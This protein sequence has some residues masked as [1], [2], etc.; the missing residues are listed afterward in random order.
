MYKTC[1]RHTRQIQSPC[2]LASSVSLN[3]T[4]GADS[5]AE[6][7]ARKAEV[8]SW[9]VQ[10]RSSQLGIGAALALGNWTRLQ[11][12]EAEGERERKKKRRY[13]ESCTREQTVAVAIAVA[14]E[15]AV[16]PDGPQMAGL[17]F[18]KSQV[19]EGGVVNYLQVWGRLSLIRLWSIACGPVWPVSQQPACGREGQD[20]QDRK[21]NNQVCEAVSGKATNVAEKLAVEETTARSAK[22][23]RRQVKVVYKNEGQV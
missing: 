16:R 7:G 18:P 6:G 11:G 5:A 21:Q 3:L 4:L 2:L 15:V 13:G 10:W 19:R 12:G 20:S 23:R 8:C 1:T 9:P 17:G 14:V 22:C